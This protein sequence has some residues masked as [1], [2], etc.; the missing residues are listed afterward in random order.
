MHFDLLNKSKKEY[1]I[2]ANPSPVLV[3]TALQILSNLNNLVNG[4]SKN[5]R[6][7]EIVEELESKLKYSIAL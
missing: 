7:T 3:P 5:T 1:M 4:D 6:L 2:S